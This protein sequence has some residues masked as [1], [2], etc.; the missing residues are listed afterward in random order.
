VIHSHRVSSIAAGL[1]AAIVA[2]ALSSSVALAHG[3]E[4]GVVVEPG[5]ATQGASVT[6]RG[7]L[8]TTGPV[9]LVLVSL[10]GDRIPLSTIDDLPDGHFTTTVGLAGDLPPGAYFLV[11]VAPDVAATSTELV[12]SPAPAGAGG[13]PDD[14]DRVVAPDASGLA[15]AA[16]AGTTGSDPA[17]PV[18]AGDDGSVPWAVVGVAAA[19][20]AAAG[21]VIV[22]RRRR[23]A[24]RSAS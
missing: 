5:T 12:V 8:A 16:T 21:G 15:A 18:T 3:G 6:V 22:D 13:G 9:E 7:D 4:Y 1:P 17:P 11:V 19:A 10:D 20:I 23:A 14:R 2:L 24:A